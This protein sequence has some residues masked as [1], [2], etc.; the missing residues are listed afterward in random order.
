[1]KVQSKCPSFFHKRS[2]V[3]TLLNNTPKKAIWMLLLSTLF[4]SFFFPIS[5]VASSA[6]LSVE[7]ETSKIWGVNE[8]LIVNVTVADAAGLYGWEV[9]LYYDPS[10]LNGIS[11]IEGPFLEAMGTTFFNATLN[12]DYNATHGQITAYNSLLGNV[13]GASGTGVLAVITFETKGLGNSWLDLDGTV[14]GDINGYPMPHTVVDGVV[15]VF[16]VIHDV[17]VRNV[18]T[19]VAEVVKGKVVNVLVEVTNEGNRTETFNV[20]LYYNETALATQTITSLPPRTNTNLTLACDT[21]D[22]TVNTTYVIKA[23]ASVVPGE[24][25]IDDNVF[26]DGILRI[27]QGVHDVA[28]VDVTPSATEFYEGRTVDVDVV[29]ENKGNYTETFNVAAYYNE[30]VIATQTVVNLEAGIRSTLTFLWDTTNVLVNNTYTIKAVAES[31]PGDINLEN[32]EFVDGF[33]TLYPI[34]LLSIEI[35]EVVPC[36]QSGRP[37]TR[38]TAGTMA[39]FQVRV[40]STSTI[41]ETVLLAVNLYDAS[42][43]A[44]GVVSFQGPIGPGITTFRL[45]LPIP[46]TAHVG[47]ANVYVNVLSDWPHLGGGP[48]GPEKTATLIIEGL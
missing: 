18:V 45:G 21:S 22:L 7:P 40:N 28:V 38:F 41:A 43:V 25:D 9:K 5:V 2:A 14:L 24:T 32:N 8:I 26:V 44:I 29:V 42:G 11:V 1:M 36:D 48:Y 39:H 31:V 17:A 23:E 4:F 46:I 34:A 19:S 30:T 33:V 13:S 12:N 6:T 47:E 16:K 3:K 20:T 27:I 35:V 37:K 10:I 15:Q